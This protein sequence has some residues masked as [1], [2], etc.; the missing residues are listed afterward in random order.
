MAKSKVYFTN[1][2]VVG[3]ENIPDKMVRLA[4]EAG[5]GDIDFE[6]KFVAIKV[7]FGEDGNLAFLRPDYARALADYI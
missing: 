1:M 3:D 4:K 7:H 2:R 6:G 5:I